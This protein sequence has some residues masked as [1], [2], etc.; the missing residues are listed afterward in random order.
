M[1][2]KDAKVDWLFEIQSL[3]TQQQQKNIYHRQKNKETPMKMIKKIE[4]KSR[5]QFT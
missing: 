3:L 2:S 4:I 1:T 5:R